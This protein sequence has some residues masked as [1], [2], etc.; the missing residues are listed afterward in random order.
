M[1]NQT[2]GR[3][4]ES[5][6]D[7]YGM[8]YMSLAGYDPQGAV[9]L[10]QTF[11]RLSDGQQQDWINGLFASHPPSQAR[12]DAN[13]KTAATLPPGG[14][15][16]VERY[17][18]AMALT[19]EAKPAYDLYDE[20]RSLLNDD[21]PDEAM[22]KAEAAIALFPEEANFYALRGDAR[23]AKKQY[24]MALTNFNSAITRRDSY[25]YYYM[26]RGQLHEELGNDDAAVSDL[27]TSINYLPNGPAYYGLGN[28]AAKRGQTDV[29]IEH[30]KQGGGR[31]RGACRGGTGKTRRA[32]YCK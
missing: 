24:D 17:R 16:G 3:G 1:I 26:Q 12:V 23:I 18:A 32:R 15:L 10:Q 7:L 4:D 22:E 13:I 5:E 28:I 20:G 6:S 9:T 8:K 19:V 21:K 30:Y 31:N 29:A 25:F 14:E 11:V 27:E 2:Y